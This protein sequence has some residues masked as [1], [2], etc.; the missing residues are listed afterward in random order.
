MNLIKILL[1]TYHARKTGSLIG[2]SF[3]TQGKSQE[4]DVFFEKL[5]QSWIDGK[6]IIKCDESQKIITLQDEKSEYL[7]RTKK[8]HPERI[9]ENLR[10]IGGFV[11][12]DKIHIV[13]FRYNSGI[14]LKRDSDFAAN[15]SKIVASAIVNI[16]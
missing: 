10:K 6:V 11:K 9:F 14:I 13:N 3:V 12:K 4:A 2:I 8:D 15:T 16:G 7:F 5:H 1:Y